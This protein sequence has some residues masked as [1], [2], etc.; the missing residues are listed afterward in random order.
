MPPTA[1]PKTTRAQLT[2]RA[3]MPIVLIAA[4][5]GLG[6]VASCGDASFDAA[7]TDHPPPDPGPKDDAAFVGLDSANPPSTQEDSGPNTGSVASASGVV[8][9][10]ASANLPAFRLC[11]GGGGDPGELPPLPDRDLMPESNVVGVEVG[12]AV[13][14]K[15]LADYGLKG[16]ERV[17]A[18]PEQLIRPG[19][20][21]DLPCKNRICPSGGTCLGLAAP[22]MQNGYYDLGTLPPESVAMG[23]RLLVIHGCAPGMADAGIA[24]CGADYK[25]ATGNM[26]LAIVPLT[27]SVPTNGD[28]PIQVNQLS[29][30]L[31][32]TLGVAYGP[33]DGTPQNFVLGADFGATFPV[34]NGGP[35]GFPLNR[36]ASYLTQGFAVTVTGKTF[37]KSLAEI[38]V[39]SA[40]QATPEEFYSVETNFAFLL[41]GNPG[42]SDT[43]GKALLESTDPG[44]LLH[45]LA[46]QVRPKITVAGGTDAGDPADAGN[47]GDAGSPKD[48]DVPD[49]G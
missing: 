11:F 41:L 12:S 27:P 19:T 37:K 49:G 17:Y 2:K 20:G 14:L 42:L 33:L 28:L 31:K 21:S 38:Q 6:G 18:I 44:L 22:G 46:V 32:G 36:K 30:S 13:R 24:G 34:G 5:I 1:M 45:L 48:A 35:I 15:E 7:V 47:P 23:V 29:D 40:P 26:Q 16:G 4:G 3:L 10:H 39:L 43:T 25:P 9:V 8:V